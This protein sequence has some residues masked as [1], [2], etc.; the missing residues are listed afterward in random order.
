M[1]HPVRMEAVYDKIPRAVSM[2]DIRSVGTPIEFTSACGEKAG[3][4]RQG[5]LDVHGFG[6]YVYVPS[7]NP[8]IYVA[9]EAMDHQGI[10]III[11]IIINK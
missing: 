10:P 4:A 6:S 9:F 2:H 1:L 8:H 3:L 5:S 11:T 7:S